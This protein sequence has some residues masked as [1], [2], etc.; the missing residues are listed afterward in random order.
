MI[1]TL[2]L[3]KNNSLLETIFQMQHESI[4]Y[5]LGQCL[6]VKFYFIYLAPEFVMGVCL[7]L[8]SSQLVV[9]TQYTIV[10]IVC[11]DIITLIFNSRTTGYL[12]AVCSN[13]L[14]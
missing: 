4:I 11:S 7:T 5:R 9:H 1:G 10:P 6:S 13:R 12:H 2:K 3:E 14:I 8:Y